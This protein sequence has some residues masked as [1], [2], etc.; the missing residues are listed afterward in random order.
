MFRTRHTPKSC[1]C[2]LIYIQ[3][4]IMPDMRCNAQPPVCELVYVYQLRVEWGGD[5]NRSYGIYTWLERAVDTNN[6][7]LVVMLLR[8]NVNMYL[9]GG[10]P[11]K[12]ASCGGRDEILDLLIQAGID[13]NVCYPEQASAIMCAIKA[14]SVET[15]LK[16]F[17]AG[18]V[19]P[20]NALELA[21]GSVVDKKKK[22]DILI[23]HKCK[24]SHL[25]DEQTL[26]CEIHYRR[27]RYAQLTAGIRLH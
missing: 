19:Y 16:L 2:S 20:R 11:L 27:T 6:I 25:T 4:V 13:V 15:V 14:A 7:G 26:A 23:N 18:A 1:V 22:I 21:E 3:P 24:N 10:F 5:I 8:Y 17:K 9:D 12:R